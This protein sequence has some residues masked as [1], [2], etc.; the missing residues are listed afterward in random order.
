[1][2]GAVRDVTEYR[3]MEDRLRQSQKMEAIG[4]LAGGVAHDFNNLLMVI[5]GYSSVLAEALRADAKLS[6]HVEQ[7]LK[8]GERAASLTRRRRQRPRTGAIGPGR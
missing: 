5:S 3:H 7:I 2:I 8:A 4:T 1:V 6:G